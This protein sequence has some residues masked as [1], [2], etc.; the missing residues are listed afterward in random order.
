[1]RSLRHALLLAAGALSGCSTLISDTELEG[2]IAVEVRTR[3][4]APIQDARL[5]LF[6]GNQQL[7][8]ARTDSQGRVLFRD[9]ARGTYGVFAELKDPVR[10]L[11]WLGTGQPEGN[12]LV[13]IDIRGGEEF[14]A[15]ITLL[16]LGTGTF[17]AVVRDNDSLPVPNIRVVA[18]TPSAIIEEKLTEADGT[19]RFDGI[20]FGSFG[21]F[22]IVPES[23]GGPG[24]APIV[25]Q[26]MFF[27]AGHF[28]RR[29]FTLQ[30]CRGTITARVRDQSNLPVADYPV[31]LYTAVATTA[32]AQT[33]ANG[34]V[35]F[36]K[37]PCDEYG[38]IIEPKSGFSATYERGFAYQ[39]GLRITLGASLTATVRVNRLP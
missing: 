31:R 4:G 8:Y 37:L 32:L 38:V 35:V 39:D 17:E 23:I 25:R 6:R 10:G 16:K 20:P 12:V 26:G 5:I 22:A 29:V 2:R 7:E 9:V 24:I 13:P 19:A 11:G 34:E 3:Q 27:D 33:G 1:M 18:Y 21:A 28:E 14:P 15:R 30:R 36:S